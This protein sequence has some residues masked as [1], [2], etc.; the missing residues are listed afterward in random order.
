MSEKYW[1][2][3]Y[4]PTQQMFSRA[5]LSDHIKRN[6]TLYLDGFDPSVCE[7]ILDIDTD[8]VALFERCKR[9]TKYRPDQPPLQE[10][11]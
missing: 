1:C 6:Q 3:V 4:N 8:D 10:L 7:V 2:F 11:K 5:L 9:F